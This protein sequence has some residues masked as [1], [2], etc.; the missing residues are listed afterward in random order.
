MD[1][2]SFV[3]AVIQALS[4]PIAILL[5]VIILRKALLD[6][7]PRL[8]NV[9]VG[10]VQ[11]Q[12]GA[13]LSALEASADAAGL[14]EMSP[15]SAWNAAQ[16]QEMARLSPRGMVIDV[17]KDLEENMH[18]A[19]RATGKP[20]S[21]SLMGAIRVLQEAGALGPD[22]LPLLSKLK[23]LEN[24]A[25]HEQGIQ[26]TPEQALEYTRLAQRIVAAMQQAVQHTRN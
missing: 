14:P 3:A 11:L 25:R 7:L 18:D 21:K 5:V 16:A 24:L 17:W 23:G 2:L 8:T 1:T 26:V 12:F 15:D 22:M 10:D 19:A 20:E 4:W 13:E 6:L 9:K